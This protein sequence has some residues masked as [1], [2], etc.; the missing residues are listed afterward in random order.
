MFRRE[1][2]L[3]ACWLDIRRRGRLVH[4]HSNFSQRRLVGELAKWA[5]IREYYPLPSMVSIL[6]TNRLFL[7][8]DSGAFIL[9]R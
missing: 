4:G 2:S 9:Y 8:S 7:H 1:L 5:S 6:K 3:A